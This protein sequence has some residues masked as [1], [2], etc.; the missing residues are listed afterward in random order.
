MP[1]RAPQMRR[2]RTRIGGATQ[3]VQA[4]G[5]ERISAA[6]EVYGMMRKIQIARANDEGEIDV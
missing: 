5:F 3:T 1:L 6:R 2:S 4:I